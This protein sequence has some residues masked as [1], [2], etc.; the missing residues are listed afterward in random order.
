MV[1]CLIL[2]LACWNFWQA[3]EEFYG[4]NTWDDTDAVTTNEWKLPDVTPYSGWNDFN[5]ERIG[6]IVLGMHRSG[7]SML[8]GLLATAFGYY[9][10]EGI[11]LI[12][13][14]N[15]NAKGY[16]ERVDIVRQNARFMQEVRKKMP[17]FHSAM[18]FTPWVIVEYENY[19]TNPYE[20]MNVTNSED[21]TTALNFMNNEYP[22][23]RNRPTIPW[24]QKDPRMCMT[25]R[26]WLPFLKKPPAVIIT[27]RHPAEVGHSVVRERVHSV[28]SAFSN[29]YNSLHR[30]LPVIPWY[31]REMSSCVRRTT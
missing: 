8:T 7:T 24:I 6:V 10:G 28:H 5:G 22:I 15:A 29:S 19:Y 2:M 23:V 31:V 20:L 14:K 17:M 1:S 13:P 4:G 21:A 12:P 18:L 3:E 11:E 16:F 26:T 25:L 9:T 30:L 27:Y